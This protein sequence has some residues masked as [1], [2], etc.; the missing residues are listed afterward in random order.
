[1]KIY[2]KENLKENVSSGLV[3][4]TN[5]INEYLRPILS[6]V[7]EMET[8]VGEFQKVVNEIEFPDPGMKKWFERHFAD[9]E[10]NIKSIKR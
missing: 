4:L 1:M 7:Y 2:E 5:Q 10:K 3:N 6:A 8:I 9:L